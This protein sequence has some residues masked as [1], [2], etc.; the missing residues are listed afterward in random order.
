MI[1]R[2]LPANVF[3]VTLR[4]LLAVLALCCVTGVYAS[5]RHPGLQ[6]PVDLPADALRA[7]AARQPVVIL[8]SLAGCPYCDVV[9]QNYL[10]TLSREHS[11]TVVREVQL[12]GTASFTDFD[13]KRV[14]HQAFSRRYGVRFAP[15][16]MFLGRDGTPLA[17]PIIGGDTAGLYGGYLDNA[18]SEATRKLASS[19]KIETSGE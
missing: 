5:G 19:R 15:T 13:G 6:A 2:A 10:T 17:A 9:R 18:F 3:L 8:F 16:V 1:L 11:G 7:A 12:N 4:R 14:S